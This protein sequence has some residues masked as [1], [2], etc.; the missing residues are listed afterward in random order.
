MIPIPPGQPRQLSAIASGNRRLIGRAGLRRQWCRRGRPC[1]DGAARDHRAGADA[2]A[3]QH[4]RAVTDPDVMAD[5]HTV[6]LPPFEEF[7]VV[8][9]AGKVGARAIGKVRL[10]RPVHRMIARIDPR[11]RRDRAEFTDCGVG[12]LRVVDDVGI[13]AHLDVEQRCA[14]ADLAIGA[15]MV[16]CNFAVGSIK[17]STESVLPAIQC[18]EIS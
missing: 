18:P 17:G 16:S 11:H 8:A 1:H 2:A 15:K 6:I 12:H 14:G 3:R 10:R 4:D 5:M 7:C 13:V 9:L